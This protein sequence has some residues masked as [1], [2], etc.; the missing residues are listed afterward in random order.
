MN[1][2]I[3]LIRAVNVAGHARLK[4]CRNVKTFIQSGNVIFGSAEPTAS[5]LETE[6]LQF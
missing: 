2:H 1:K 5:V 3:A 4:I 6:M